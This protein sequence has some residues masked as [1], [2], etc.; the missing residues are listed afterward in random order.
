VTSLVPEAVQLTASCVITNF[1][2]NGKLGSS[3][4]SEIIDLE[5]MGV[6]EGAWAEDH[7]NGRRDCVTS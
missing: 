6:E 5:V 1:T 2:K 7:H 4:R 3:A